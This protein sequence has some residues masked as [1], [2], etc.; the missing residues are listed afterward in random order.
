M[1]TGKTLHQVLTEVYR[2]LGQSLHGQEWTPDQI[3]TLNYWNLNGKITGS[4][5]QSETPSTM[6]LG[7]FD[8]GLLKMV[9]KNESE[10]PEGEK[11]TP[12]QTFLETIN[13]ERYDRLNQVVHDFFNRDQIVT[14]EWCQIP[15]DGESDSV[16]EDDSVADCDSVAEDDSVAVDDDDVSSWFKRYSWITQTHVDKIQEFEVDR[17]MM[18]D[19]VKTRDRQSLVELGITQNLR[20]NKIFQEWS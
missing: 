7:G 20:Q 8:I 5:V 13:H 2:Q 19:I 1:D 18:D 14:E 10:M 11:V 12:Y 16:A 15:T 3:P 17:E 9:L 4:P 6:F